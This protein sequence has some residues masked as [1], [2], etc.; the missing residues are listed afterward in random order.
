MTIV[1]RYTIVRRYQH[2]NRSS[3]GAEE[4]LG[5]RSYSLCS[6]GL[7]ETRLLTERSQIFC[8]RFVLCR[9]R[10]LILLKPR[11]LSLVNCPPPP[12]PWSGPIV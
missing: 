5:I 10:A 1:G 3:A 12:G 11:R 4:S 6:D 9:K 2:D 7:L 8:A